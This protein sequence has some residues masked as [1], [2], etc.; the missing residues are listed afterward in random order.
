MNYA[1]F[2]YQ[3][4][5]K[6]LPK[7]F[8]IPMVILLGLYFAFAFPLLVLR[9]GPYVE[10]Y[11]AGKVPTYSIPFRTLF[12]I[13]EGYSVVGGIVSAALIFAVALFG[14]LL[15][16]GVASIIYRLLRGKPMKRLKLHD[17]SLLPTAP[18]PQTDGTNPLAQ[19]ERIGIILAGGGAKGAYQAGALQAIHEFLEKHQALHKV[20]MIA[21][22]S[23]GSWNSLF[24][25]AGMVKRPDE[26]VPSVLEQWWHQ[27][28]VKSVIRPALY[29][30]LRQNYLL[31]AQPW[32][33][34]FNRFFKDNAKA[35]ELLM[36]HINHQPAAGDHGDCD[37]AIH[38]YLTRANVALGKLEFTTNRND[39]SAVQKNLP[40]GLRPRQRA[41]PDLWRAAES[42]DDLH[43]AVF[44]SMDIPPL[45]KN[46]VIGDELF[47]DGGVID[48][49]PIKFGTEFENCDLLF[50]L[51]LNAS[52]AQKPD[53][54]SIVK[55]LFRVMDVRQGVLERNSFK[56]VYLYNEL[57]ALR[58]QAEKY[59]SALSDI[60]SELGTLR[61]TG[62]NTDSLAQ[63]I[64]GAIQLKQTYGKEKAGPG[65]QPETQAERTTKEGSAI[66]RALYRRHKMV[67]VFSICPAPELAINTAEFWKTEESGKAFRLM[68][69]NTEYELQ[70][71]FYGDTPAP[72]WIRMARVGP[73][74]EVTYLTDF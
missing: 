40:S 63:K 43:D 69:R 70:K 38:F 65:T 34:T 15:S 13:P 54:R 12:G 56:M 20:R 11:V 10:T 47:E 36:H 19:Y 30:P 22:T 61:N 73:E 52:T 35:S 62:V 68:H 21:G 16:Y 14:I 37:N 45:F 25:L 72:D 4:I 27:V 6:R 66:S 58:D 33:E 53:Q 28:D 39:L 55:R 44:A 5:L 64:A 60:N 42:V 71:F 26:K 24:W 23:I 17:P 31:S 2:L 3:W 41:T 50:I 49:L 9:A 74:G 46:S 57:A 51:P 32:E 8:S 67:Q 1:I 59:Q 48:N 18:E 29:V 7:A